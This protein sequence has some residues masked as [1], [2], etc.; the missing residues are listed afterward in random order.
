MSQRGFTL[1]ELVVV[2]AIAALLLALA[3][4]A[5]RQQALRA[6]RSEALQAIAAA[7]ACMERHRAQRG[8]YAGH[9]C[10][11]GGGSQYVVIV[12]LEGTAGDERYLVAAVPQGGQQADACGTLGLDHLGRRSASGA[13]AAEKCW[14]GR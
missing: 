2:L 1:V 4:P 5:Y 10:A 11:G 3:V 12:T 14:A 13:L 9:G 8:L 7:A 6:A